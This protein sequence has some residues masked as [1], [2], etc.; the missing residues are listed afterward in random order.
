[1]QCLLCNRQL[2]LKL[3]IRDLLLP[4]RIVKP[5]ICDDCQQNFTPLTGQTACP[6]CSRPQEKSVLCTECN[7]W[8]SVY[9][10]QLTHHA[11]YRYD[12]AMKEF[13]QRYKFAGD[14]RLRQI[15][16]SEFVSAI[17]KCQVDMVVP[18]P[19]TEQTMRTRGFNQVEGLLGNLPVNHLLKCRDKE[20]VAQ[21]KKNRWERLA[22]KQPF[23]LINEAAVRRKRI[24]LVDDIYTTGR[25]LYHA[26][27]LL[28]QAGAATVISISLAR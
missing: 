22:S 9:P 11:L 7:E 14:Y 25:T 10:W 2:R 12:D 17:S 13:M 1:M 5:L 16:S 3:T 15:F 26:A 24:L 19:V 27:N 20:K 28:Y 21:S 6:G 4:T 18:I 8:R 23:I